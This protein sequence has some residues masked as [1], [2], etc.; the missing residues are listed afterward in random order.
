VTAWLVKFLLP[1]IDDAFILVFI[2]LFFLN[3]LVFDRLKHDLLFAFRFLV[4]IFF[5]LPEPLLSFNRATKTI[6]S[7]LLG[8]L[9]KYQKNQDYQVAIHVIEV[10]MTLFRAV[11]HSY[12]EEVKSDIVK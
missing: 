1:N 3:N 11:V 2:L 9:L 7:P 4:D 10:S 8:I 5:D 6:K 12:P